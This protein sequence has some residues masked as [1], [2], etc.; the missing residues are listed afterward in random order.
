[1]IIM[2][3]EGQVSWFYDTVMCLGRDGF[4]QLI[5]VVHILDLWNCVVHNYAVLRMV[6]QHE[7]SLV[8]RKD[9]NIYQLGVSGSKSSPRKTIRKL[10]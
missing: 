2:I 5:S 3:C 10:Y 6:L 8:S 4:G 9:M 1:M 7:S